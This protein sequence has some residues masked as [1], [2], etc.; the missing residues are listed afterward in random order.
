MKTKPKFIV[1]L[2]DHINSLSYFILGFCIHLII[3]RL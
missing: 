2:E 1:L 3:T